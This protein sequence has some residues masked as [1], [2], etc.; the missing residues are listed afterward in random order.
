MTSHLDLLTIDSEQLLAATG[1]AAAGQAE[2]RALAKDYC[3]DVYA[4]FKNAK[5]ITR[6]MG[7][8]CLDEAGYGAFK[9]QLDRY[10]P[11]K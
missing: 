10:F 7:E 5:T 6:P 1:G 11:K 2:L 9:S 4:Q 8:R 3:P